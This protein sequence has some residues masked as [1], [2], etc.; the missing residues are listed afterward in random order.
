MRQKTKKILKKTGLSLIAFFV[1]IVITVLSIFYSS[2]FQSYITSLI[3]SKITKNSNIKINIDNVDFA[4]FSHFILNKID[5]TRNHKDTLFSIKSLDIS[6]RDIDFDKQIVNINSLTIDSSFTNIQLESED[7]FNIDDFIDLFSSDSA[8]SNKPWLVYV[9]NIIVKDSRFVYHTYNC[10]KQNFGMNYWDLDVKHL[11][12]YISDIQLYPDSITCTINQ[13]EAKEKSGFTLNSFSGNCLVSDTIIKVKNLQLASNN[14]RVNA[15]YYNMKFKKF[16]DFLDYNHKV[17]MECKLRNSFADINEIAYFAPALHNMDIKS[18]VS[19]YF[20]GTVNNFKGKDFKFL[21]GD[22]SL[23]KLNFSFSG[24][25]NYEETFMYIKVDSLITNKHDIE[26]IKTYPF[27]ANQYIKLPDKIGNVGNIVYQGNFTGFYNDFVAYG[28]LNSGIGSIKT[29]VMLRKESRAKTKL[30]GTVSSAGLNIGEI[31][32][33]EKIGNISFNTSINGFIT[34]DSVKAKIKG[35]INSVNILDYNY[36]NI[37]IDGDIINKMFDGLFQLRD[38]NIVMDFMG[39]I[40]FNTNTPVMNFTADVMHA[41]LY[42]LHIYQKDSLANI[43]FKM[44]SKF[45]GIDIDKITGYINVFNLKFSSKNKTTKLNDIRFSSRKQD[46]EMHAYLYSDILDIKIDGKYRLIDLDK[47]AKYI[48]S[49]FAPNFFNV[50]KNKIYDNNFTFTVNFKENKEFLS[51]FKENTQIIP[52]SSIKGTINTKKQEIKILSH[53]PYASYNGTI[54]SNIKSYIKTDSDSLISYIKLDTLNLSNKLY[55]TNLAFKINTYNNQSDVDITWQKDSTNNSDI[56]TKISYIKEDTLSKIKYEFIP[57]YFVIDSNLW[58]INDFNGE[59][60]TNNITINNMIINNDKQYLYT[61][62]KLSKNTKDSLIVY[63]N[64]IDIGSIYNTL[65]G[66]TPEISGIFNGD[67]IIKDF[68]GN[69]KFNSKLLID[70]LKINKQD[71]GK[72]KINSNFL[73]EDKKIKL[74]AKTIDKRKFN[75]IDILGDID[76]SAEKLYIDFNI[77]K[78]SAKLINP[79]IKDY[80]S[81]VKGLMSANILIDGKFSSPKITARIK[82]DRFSAMVDYLKT[83][84]SCSDSIIIENNKITIDNFKIY[85]E[86]AQMAIVNGN[87]DLTNISSPKFNLKLTANNFTGLNTTQKDNELFYGKAVID[88]DILF[89][90]TPDMLNLGLDVT[91]QKGT[92][93]SIPLSNPETV[94]SSDYIRFVNKY[95]TIQKQ[96]KKKQSSVLDYLSTNL[97]L[98][99]TPKADVNII[100]DEK[101]GDVIKVRGNGDLTIKSNKKNPFYINGEYIISKGTYLFTLQNLLNKKFNIKSG[102]YIRWNGDVYDAET[103]VDAIYKLKASPYNLT[104]NPEDK[105]RIPIECELLLSDKLLQPNIQFKLNIP[106]ANDRLRN[107]IASLSTEE[108]NKQILFLLVTN[109]FYTN[110]EILSGS[111]GTEQL[112]GN[113]IGKTTG[114]MLSNQVSNWL[115]QISNDFD[116][117]VNYRPGDDISKDE[118]EIALSTQI[119]NDRVFLNGNVGFGE[120]KTTNSTTSNVAGSFDIEVL[121]NKKGNLRLKGYNHVNDNYDYKNSLYTQGV[122]IFYREEFNSLDE[123]K[124]KYLKTLKSLLE[125]KFEK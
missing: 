33:T 62:G 90:G 104:L 60:Y 124:K 96:P 16:S 122:G 106:Q 54:F 92:S 125:K 39:D 44:V 95:D 89:T 53:I 123:L 84:Y 24:L 67:V 79:Y 22:K 29:D 111:A 23:L 115:S 2:A 26:T 87:I 116:I 20:S 63:M 102:S 69:I 65:I 41:N 119:L 94:S 6:L 80:L 86:N 76:L 12:L 107:T 52:G 98:K 25:P 108:L 49:A 97:K 43:S 58:Y 88:G 85:D 110:E 21:Y 42:P 64:D 4:L 8:T 75:N 103:K 112:S 38:S 31:L 93:L 1:V 57:S 71:F 14:T 46:N 3:S 73:T 5:I 78:L 114:E 61:S 66:K 17:K 19:G 121:L 59:I 10:P 48:M 34:A 99:F 109:N 9:Q 120:Y 51:F 101:V 18:G 118:L 27:D 13:I 74:L 32:E 37:A 56:F 82:P 15:D 40:D 55:I 7:K 45:T 36:K 105:P 30:Q 47:S 50:N 11:N 68:F 91:F 77:T 81:D 100:F 35:N 72:I 113:A 28:K 83:R 117:G 70:S